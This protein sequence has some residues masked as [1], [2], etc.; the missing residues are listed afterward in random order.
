MFD[1]H[2]YMNDQLEDQLQ[3]ELELLRKE[4]ETLRFMLEAMRIKYNILESHIQQRTV[5]HMG[6]DLNQLDI[7]NK[8]ARS[9][10]QFPLA[11]YSNKTSTPSQF[12]VRTDSKDNSLVSQL[13]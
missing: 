13:T 3:A 6:F 9:D 5:E 2:I 10:Q 12:L 8:R 7:P 1:I 4:N 11:N